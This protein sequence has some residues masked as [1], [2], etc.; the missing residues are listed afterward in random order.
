MSQRL[1]ILDAAAALRVSSETIRRR[2]KGRQLKFEKDNTGKYWVF[3]DP[4]QT[5]P[6]N[7]PTP[8]LPS[9]DVEDLRRQINRLEELLK[10]SHEAH[11]AD[12]ELLGE[13]LKSA[14][15]ERAQLM[16]T[17]TSLTKKLSP[18]KRRWWP[19]SS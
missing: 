6:P 13:T 15:L 9:H 16:E 12:R 14:Q 8:S 7:T 5:S 19:W 2:I 4:P 17:I 18:E 1:S 11:T 3:I 10:A